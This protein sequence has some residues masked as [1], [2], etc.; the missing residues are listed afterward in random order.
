MSLRRIRAV[1]SLCNGEFAYTFGEAQMRVVIL[2]EKKCRGIV[3]KPREFKK[4]REIGLELL[5]GLK[6]SPSD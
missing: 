5:R 2:R 6:V 4:H 1:E 3:R